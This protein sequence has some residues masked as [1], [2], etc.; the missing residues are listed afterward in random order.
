MEVIDSEDSDCEGYKSDANLDS[1]MKS[2]SELRMVLIKFQLLFYW[3]FV[4]YR[5]N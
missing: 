3:W 2:E 4:W 1:K 5:E